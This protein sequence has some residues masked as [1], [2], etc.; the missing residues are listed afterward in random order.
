MEEPFHRRLWIA[1]FHK[2]VDAIVRRANQ[3]VGFALQV[4]HEQDLPE[5]WINDDVPVSRRLGRRNATRFGGI[6]AGL[7]CR[8]LQPT[9]WP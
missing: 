8:R 3:L 7:T 1:R 4:A 5:D 6:R 9:C 2:D